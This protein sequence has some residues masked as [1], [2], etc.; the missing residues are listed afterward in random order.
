ML[1][2]IFALG[3]CIITGFAGLLWRIFMGFAVLLIVVGL[4]KH[5]VFIVSAFSF[6]NPYGM[7]IWFRY[8]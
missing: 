7:T 1:S 3:V 8:A 2:L 5:A 4:S 6:S